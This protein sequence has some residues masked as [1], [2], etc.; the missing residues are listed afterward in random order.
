[1]K[2]VNFK[3]IIFH[4]VAAWFFIHA[5]A[6]ASLLYDVSLVKGYITEGESYFSIADI[7]DMHLSYFLMITGLSR[8][9]GFI[10][11]VCIS[12][13]IARK[14]KIH[15]L[16]IIPILIIGYFFLFYDFLGW[17]YVK[18]IF[19]LPGN[20]SSILFVKLLINSFVLLLL[21]VAIFWFVPG[22]EK[23]VSNTVN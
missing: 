2:T 3:F 22:K 5:F 1:M 15:W 16:N 12:F 23:T 6:T 4:L 13:I 11:A 17:N 20:I 18:F 19:L 9:F 8:F 21:G 10:V 14:K 7:D